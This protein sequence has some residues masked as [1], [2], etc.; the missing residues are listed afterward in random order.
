MI[1]VAIVGSGPTGC[2]VAEFLAKKHQTI[3]IDIFDRLPTPFGLVRA[4]V[5]P[6]HQQTKRISQ[7]FERTLQRDNVRFIGNVEIGRTISYDSLK[8][9]YHAIVIATGAFIDKPL[10]GIADPIKGIYGSA[11]FAGWYNSHP[12]HCIQPPELNGPEVAIIGTGNVALDIARVLSKTTAELSDSDI[13]TDTEKAINE[14]GITDIYIIGRRG[15][16]HASFTNMELTELNKLE[17]CA[18]L[19]DADRLPEQTPDISDVGQ[20]RAV[21]QNLAT[22]REYSNHAQQNQTI[23]LHLMFN[24]NLSGT[25][26]SD[27]KLTALSLTDNSDLNNDL[28]LPAQTLISAIGYRS[29]VIP[30]IPFNEQHGRFEHT[31]G[32]IEPGVYCAG[33]CKRGPQGVIPT[34]RSDANSTGKRIL[35]DLTDTTLSKAG[36]SG[37][38]DQLDQQPPVFYED[39]QKIDNAEQSRATNQRPRTKFSDT[40]AM[41]AQ[42]I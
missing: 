29:E 38:A 11:H 17:N 19:T 4:G 10:P 28:R 21:E 22:L 2:F 34:N 3:Q 33:W 30:G 32:L 24:Y 13:N 16:E 41:I 31:D 1:H 42:I 8:Q 5:A 40:D 37:I 26:N 12:E 23:R 25:E 20:R 36:F 15:P 14:A 7:Q 39:W 27:G 35:A 6:D 18:I 9:H